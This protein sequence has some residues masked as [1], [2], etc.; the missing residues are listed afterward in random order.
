MLIH[1]KREQSH[2]VGGIAAWKAAGLPTVT[3]DPGTGV[4]VDRQ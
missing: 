2:L 1:I 3:L 4:V